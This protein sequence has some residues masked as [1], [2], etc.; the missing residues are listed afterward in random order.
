MRGDFFCP[1]TGTSYSVS[2]LYLKRLGSSVPR[3]RLRVVCGSHYSLSVA[4]ISG[5]AVITV[6]APTPDTFIPLSK[7]IY[8]LYSTRLTKP[9]KIYVP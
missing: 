4:D 5:R 1:C 2:F 9:L 3:R 8:I 6:S 7:G